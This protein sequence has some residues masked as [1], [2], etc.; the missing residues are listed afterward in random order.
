M[1]LFLLKNK[2]NILS[3]LR[4]FP[5][6]PF[7]GRAAVKDTTIPT[8]GGPDGKSPIFVRKGQNVEYST[9]AMHRRQDI[10]GP[11]ADFFRPERWSEPRKTGYGGFEYLPFNGGPRICLGRKF[12]K[13]ALFIAFP[14]FPY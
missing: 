8:G 5:V 12:T 11:D 6:V 14:H 2:A 1:C 3:A 13:Q 7:N 4:L 10:W 9:Y